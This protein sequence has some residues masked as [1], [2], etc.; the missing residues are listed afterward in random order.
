MIDLNFCIRIR[1]IQNVLVLFL[2]LRTTSSAGEDVFSLHSLC[3]LY[4]KNI[5][6]KLLKFR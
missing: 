1:V 3:T 4:V 6:G 5:I 2:N